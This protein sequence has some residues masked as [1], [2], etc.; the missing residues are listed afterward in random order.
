MLKLLIDEPRAAELDE[1][2]AEDAEDEEVPVVDA[3]EV[4]VVAVV[5]ALVVAVVPAAADVVPEVVAPL[6]INDY[7]NDVLSR[8]QKNSRCCRRPCS[9]GGGTCGS[10]ARG[11]RS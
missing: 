2:V 5:D 4:P 11:A 9:Y 3:L 6:H 1:V 10:R 7:S 8:Y